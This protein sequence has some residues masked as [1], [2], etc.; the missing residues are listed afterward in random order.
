MGGVACVKL[1]LAETQS[2]VSGLQSQFDLANTIV[3]AVSYS[4]SLTSTAGLYGPYADGYRFGASPSTASWSS[5]FSDSFMETLDAGWDSFS[6]GQSDLYQR[7]GG[8]GNMMWPITS[9]IEG[10]GSLVGNTVGLLTAMG[11]SGL[12]PNVANY[13]ES[14][15]NSITTLGGLIGDTVSGDPVAAGKL[16][17]AAVSMGAGV[18]LTRRLDGPSDSLLATNSGERIAAARIR[19]ETMLQDDVGFNISPVGWD[20]YPTIG[21]NG[22]FVSDRQGVMGYFGDVTGKSEITIH[23]NV[24]MQIEKDMGL[25]LG[26]LTD[27]FKVRQVKSI[28]RLGPTSPMEGNKYF[29]GAGN[30]LPGGA[31]EVVIRSIPTVDNELV[32]TLLKVKVG[33]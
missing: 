18:L 26:T 6:S 10:F 9:T 11:P 29:L 23:P 17:P 4:N 27:G 24:A 3:D 22:T 31:P 32:K 33:Q 13:W 1:C 5:Q 16:G 7:T 15:W 21:R 30:H 19:Q 25:E 20:Q 8:W 14:K 28:Q 12:K 2:I